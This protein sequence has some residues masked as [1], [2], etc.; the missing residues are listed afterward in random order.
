MKDIGFFCRN[1]KQKEMSYILYFIKQNIS[2]IKD[3]CTI[4]LTLTATV[5]SF[6]TYIKAKKTLLQ[7]MKSEVIHIQTNTFI[8]ILKYIT[9]YLNENEIKMYLDIISINLYSLLIDCGYVFA[10][11]EELKK[12]IEDIK[13]GDIIIRN[14]DGI[15]EELEIV[16][17]FEEKSQDTSNTKEN[18]KKKYQD[19]KKGEVKINLLGYTKQYLDIID[20]LREYASNPLLPSIIVNLLNNLTQEIYINFTKHIKETIENFAIE[21]SKLDNYKKINIDGIYNKFNRRR[22]S[23]ENTLKALKKEIRKYLRIDEEWQ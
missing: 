9:Q 22:I 7:P 1:F 5:I 18:L 14:N 20:K 11:N 23:H 12:H 3:I 16:S 13:Y 19:L 2:W 15:I 17:S 8:E 4:I 21:F 10:N 6:L